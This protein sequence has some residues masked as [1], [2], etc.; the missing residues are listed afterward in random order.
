MAGFAAR[1]ATRAE[2][3]FM[4]CRTLFEDLVVALWAGSHPDPDSVLGLANDHLEARGDRLALWDPGDDTRGWDPRWK[5]SKHWIGKSLHTLITELDDQVRGTTLGEVSRMLR[6]ANKEA[7]AYNQAVVHHA[8]VGM[9]PWQYREVLPSTRSSNSR[10]SAW[11]CR[12]WVSAT[13]PVPNHSAG[14]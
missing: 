3:L 10:R 1:S 13:S 8:L 6:D 9:T 7:M 4:L 12:R 5:G 14:S 2:R 11:E